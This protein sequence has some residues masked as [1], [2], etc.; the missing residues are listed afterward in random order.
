MD[1]SGFSSPSV[2]TTEN[3][4]RQRN[5]ADSLPSL[6]QL[7]LLYEEAAKEEAAPP[8]SEPMPERRQ[9]SPSYAASALRADIP[10]LEQLTSWRDEDPQEP[11]VRAEIPAASEYLSRGRTAEPV[12]RSAPVPAA[13][14]RRKPAARRIRAVAAPVREEPA[15][16]ERRFRRDDGN[17]APAPVR[18]ETL[19]PERRLRRDDGE[20][21]AAPV[22]EEAAQPERRFFRGA[23]NSAAA[24]DIPTLSQLNDLLEEAKTSDREPEWEPRQEPRRES[25]RE[26]RWEA[27]RESQR[28]PRWEV[29]REPQREPRWEAPREPQRE[30]R[31]EAPREPQRESRWEAPREPQQEPRRAAQEEPQQERRVPDVVWEEPFSARPTRDFT[32]ADIPSLEALQQMRRTADREPEEEESYD[33][34]S[35]ESAAPAPE[36]EPEDRGDRLP[37]VAQLRAQ[38]EEEK[39]YGN[40]A[41]QDSVRQIKQVLTDPPEKEAESPVPQRS[42]QPVSGQNADGSQKVHFIPYEDFLKEEDFDDFTASGKN[43]ETGASRFGRRNRSND[44]ES[45]AKAFRQ[46][47][48]GSQRQRQEEADAEAA[49]QDE[50]KKKRNPKI[51]FWISSLL[52]IS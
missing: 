40:L 34:P 42:S 23:G 7:R 48:A 24:F 22:R 43:G 10:S 32:A 39:L 52:R 30:P 6:S 29:P 3:N 33:V 15:Q 21:V 2:R 8:V 47:M 1:N 36:R 27:P 18:A 20:P 16:P 50:A 28:E 35:R 5:A 13:T 49:A 31:W 9:P 17:P 38:L 41:F 37:T 45:E 51:P 14:P 4:P 25:Q 19:Q 11:E 46:K 12:R 44:G 26:P